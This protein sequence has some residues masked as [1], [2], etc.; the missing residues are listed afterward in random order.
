MKLKIHCRKPI[1]CLVVV[2]PVDMN[3]ETSTHLKVPV[4]VEVREACL[5]PDGAVAHVTQVV[6]MIHG[7]SKLPILFRLF[8]D[9]TLRTS[10]LKR[11]M[12]GISQKMPRV[13]TH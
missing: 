6:R 9:P 10:Q 5:G 3:V 4:A 12:P 1:L 13:R 2:R 11:D 7:R 8:A